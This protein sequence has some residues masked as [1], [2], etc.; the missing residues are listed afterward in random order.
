MSGH[1]EHAAPTRMTMP[2]DIAPDVLDPR[3]VDHR[4]CEAL[5]G[6]A[7]MSGWV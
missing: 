7:L 4:L 5:S 3:C 6:P 1:L 2:F